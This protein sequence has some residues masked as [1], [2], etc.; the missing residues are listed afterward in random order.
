MVLV[1][2]EY[3]YE[4]QRSKVPAVQVT[5][6]LQAELGIEVCDYP[7]S[8]VAYAAIGESWTRD[9]FDRIIVAHAKANGMA[10]LI[11][12]DEHI[13]AHYPQAIW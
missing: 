8:K 1:E 6:K 5:A 12:A 3:L 4:I 10:P 9:A 11:T 2:L 13:Q 7:F